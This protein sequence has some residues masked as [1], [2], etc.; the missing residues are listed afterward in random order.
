MRTLRHGS[1][2]EKIVGYIDPPTSYT[3]PHCGAVSHNPNDVAFRYC[4]RC[5]FWGDDV[6]IEAT[7]GAAVLPD[8]HRDVLVMKRQAEPPRFVE[9]LV[10]TGV[11]CFGLGVVS[12]MAALMLARV[13]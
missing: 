1:Q 6:V 10:L 5:N 13:W 11:L 3:C 12:T 8:S 7:P 2:V 9:V 4:G